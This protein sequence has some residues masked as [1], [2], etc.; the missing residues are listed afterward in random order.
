MET[1]KSET[2]PKKKVVTYEEFRKRQ[3]K[4]YAL[5]RNEFGIPERAHIGFTAEDEEIIRTGRA[6]LIKIF[7]L[8]ES[9]TD[10]DIVRAFNI[11]ALELPPDATDADIVKAELLDIALAYQDAEE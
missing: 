11:D 5:Q 8:E 3:D 6:K 2:N 1:E 10:E 7:N 4:K 9:A